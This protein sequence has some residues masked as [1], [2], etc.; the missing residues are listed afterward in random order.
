MR[1]GKD[2][3]EFWDTYHF[4][5][6]PASSIVSHPGPSDEVTVSSRWHLSKFL[7]CVDPPEEQQLDRYKSKTLALIDFQ[8]SVTWDMHPYIPIARCYTSDFWCLRRSRSLYLLVLQMANHLHWCPHPLWPNTFWNRPGSHWPSW[9]FFVHGSWPGRARQ[10]PWSLK[11]TSF[12]LSKGLFWSLSKPWFQ[13]KW[14]CKDI[15]N[16]PNISRNFIIIHH[17]QLFINDSMIIILQSWI[18][19]NH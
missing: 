8:A 7:Q 3:A 10:F 15:K 13:T 12:L 9:S 2:L 17:Y 16:L 11:H 1:Y 5:S 19:I 14:N 6:F 4:L 18:I